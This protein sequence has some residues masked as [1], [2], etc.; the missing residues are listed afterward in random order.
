VTIPFDAL[1]VG[2]PWQSR[3]RKP[4]RLTLIEGGVEDVGKRAISDT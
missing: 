3:L 1:S 2:L 4:K